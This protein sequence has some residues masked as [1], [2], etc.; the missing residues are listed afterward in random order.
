MPGVEHKLVLHR[1]VHVGDDWALLPLDLNQPTG[2]GRDIFAFGN[3]HCHVIA[4][5]QA[6]VRIGLVAAEADQYRLVVHAEAVFVDGHIPGRQHGDDAGQG[7]GR[8]GVH[9]YHAGVGLAAEQYAAEKQ[10]GRGQVAGIVSF[11]GD[12]AMGVNA[13]GHARA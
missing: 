2:A 4:L 11:A 3:D 9:R 8:V 12:F 5:P 10:I 13:F 1:F 7:F 6:D